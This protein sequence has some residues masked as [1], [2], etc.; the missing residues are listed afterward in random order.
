MGL[1]EMLMDSLQE[2][3]EY[4]ARQFLSP[5]PMVDVFQNREDKEMDFAEAFAVPEQVAN[6]RMQDSDLAL[7]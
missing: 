1:A 7:R 5:Q 3:A 6:A 4:F 2:S